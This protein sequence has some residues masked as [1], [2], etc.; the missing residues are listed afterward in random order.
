MEC[1]T[2]CLAPASKWLD[3]IYPYLSSIPDSLDKY[4]SPL[5][6][7][8][9]Q[10][11]GKPLHVGII[12]C[13]LA[14]LRCAD[15]LLQRGIRV[16]MLE[17]R[18]RIG[19]RVCQS[20]LGSVSVDLG[21]NW[22]HG[23]RNNPL[24]E[25]SE[26]S[27]TVTDSWE[28]LQTTFDTDGRLLDPARS[29]KVADFI[30][31]TIDRAFTLSQKDCANIPASKSLL[32]FFREELA[33]SGFSQAEKDACLESAKMWGAYI[34][35]P[36]ER[37]S[38]KFFLLEECLEGTNLFVASTYKNI[39]QHVA[40]PALKGAEIRFNETV[41]ALEGRTRS[42]GTDS[43]VLVRT[44]AGKEYHFDEVVATFPLGWLKQN[45]QAFSPA[46]PQRL[47]EAID[48]ISY[49]CLEKI[50]VTFPAA[51]WRREPAASNGI[52]PT[53][54]FF[55][56]SYVDHPSTPYWNQECLSLADLPGSCAHPTLLFYTY[57]TCAEHVVSSISAHPAD[58][59]E[60]YSILY[61]FLL[62][63]I[64]RL[65]GYD[66]QSPSCKPT[67]FLATEWQT[68]PL[69]G[70]GSYSNFQTGLTDGLGDIEAMREGM[71]VD[72]GIWLAGEHTAPIVG[73]G[74]AAGAY[75]SGEEVARRICSM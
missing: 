17:A 12:G 53:F 20:N 39:L 62:P 22:I 19:G 69:A 70:N 11:M 72:R 13:G 18:D 33:Q 4:L 74:T 75:W 15:V 35:S 28:G 40:R 64:S 5:P 34:G 6:L 60:Y 49:G 56:P 37:Q 57:G 65:P 23:T 27:G 44:S 68:D 25:I 58:S 66:E 50:Y 71:G 31:T 48:H 61:S 63:Y 1:N 43:R 9:I 52:N 47:S 21:P 59:E 26:L 46:M 67:G 36:I 30:W 3:P 55:S 32:D 24:V 42:I 14:G 8:Q 7:V 41:V 16:T 2:N 38:L 51:F 10:P 73:L 54:Q 45:K 29:A